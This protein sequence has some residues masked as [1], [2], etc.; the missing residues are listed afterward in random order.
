MDHTWT[1]PF[2]MALEK[3]MCTDLFGQLFMQQTYQ[4]HCNFDFQQHHKNVNPWQQISPSE[5]KLALII[6]LDALMECC[7]GQVRKA[8]FRRETL[9]FCDWNQ[10]N[11][12]WRQSDRADMRGS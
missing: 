6:V 3:Q 1:L 8:G 12:D 5:A 4:Q 10:Q 9:A 7:S 2:Y 11:W